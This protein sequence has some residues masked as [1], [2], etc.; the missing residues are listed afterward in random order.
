[1]IAE[2]IDSA[3]IIENLQSAE[4]GEVLAEIL[5]AMVAAGRV[6]AADQPAISKL[7]RKR[8]ELGSTGIGNG[9]AVPHVK[10]DKIARLSL[11]LARSEPGIEYQA[12]DGRPVQT[13]FLILAPE[14]EPDGHLKALR[15][16]STLARDADFRRFAQAAGDE[17]ALRDLLREMSASA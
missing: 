13:L 6:D 10:S 8:E 5:E 17:A 1:M 14:S 9:V 3:V 15:W 12:I 2:L 4:K 11:G 16:V 7:L